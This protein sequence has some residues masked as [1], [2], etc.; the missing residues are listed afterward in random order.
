MLKKA[1]LWLGILVS[2]GLQAG[3]M[4]VEERGRDLYVRSAVKERMIED[5]FGNKD[6]V[7]R[8][9]VSINGQ[10]AIFVLGRDSYYYTLVFDGTHVAVDCVYVDGRNKYNGARVS[11]GNCGL[12]TLLE[13]NFYEIGMEL[14]AEQNR[15]IYSFDTKAVAHGGGRYLIGEMNGMEFLDEYLSEE[16]LED[17]RP[18]KLVRWRGRCYKFDADLVFLTKV[19]GAIRY[20]DVVRS[21]DPMRVQRLD[22]DDVRRLVVDRCL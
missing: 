20:V 3:G 16:T 5:V 1:V 15:D 8:V 10:P 17:S 12:G 22:G 18:N 14:L 21:L 19:G 6:G 2:S 4:V 9:L 13:P 11:V 7:D